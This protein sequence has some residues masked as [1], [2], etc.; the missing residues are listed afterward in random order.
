MWPTLFSIGSFSL[1]TMSIF[2]VLAFLTM[3]F[4]FWRRGREEHYRE[5]QL[6][7]GFLLSVAV[8]AVVAR[9]GFVIFNFDQFGWSLFSWFDVFS[10]P[11]FSG[12]VG[13]IAATFYLYRYALKHKWDAF[14]ILDFW[15]TSVSAAAIFV[16]IGKFLEGSGVGYTTNLPWGM[17]F[18]QLLEPHHPVQ[19]Y[20]VVFFIGLFWYLYWVEYHYRTY[21]WYRAGKRAAQTGFITAMFVIFSS[22]FFLLMTLFQPS[23]LVVGDLTLD[24]LLYGAGLLWGIGLLYARSGRTWPWQSWRQRGL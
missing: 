20:F 4:V 1:Q 23:S 16:F 11:G 5:D 8:G 9:I 19:L 17:T 21:E 2:M 6:F 24:R 14:E 3:S 22:A 7:D 10:H 13:L 18:P 15:L 12:V